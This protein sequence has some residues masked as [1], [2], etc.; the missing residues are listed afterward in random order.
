MAPQRDDALGS[1]VSQPAR[2]I[3]IEPD[4]F[5]FPADVACR[6]QTA[7]LALRTE[8]SAA[9]AFREPYIEVGHGPLVYRQYFER[10]VGGRRY[11]NLSPLFA[12]RRAAAPRVELRGGS[13]RWGREGALLLFDPP[14]AEG[15]TLVV[16]P[17]PDDAEIAAFGLYAGRRSWVVTVTAGEKGSPGGSAPRSPVATPRWRALLRV[18]DSI[19]VPQLGGV[20]QERCVNLVYPDGRL[21]DLND[22][23]PRPLAIACE[24]ELSRAM[25]RSWNRAPEFRDGEAGC[26][27]DGLVAELRTVLE[28]TRPGVVACPHPLLDGHPD[29]VFTTV[30]LEEA[31]RGMVAEKPLLLLYVV[32]ARAAPAFPFG[33][34]EGWVS[35]PPLGEDEAQADSIYS[36]PLPPDLQQTKYFAV[37]CKHDDRSYD[38][39]RPQTVAEVG[40]SIKRRL[41]ALL[42]GDGLHPTSFLRRAPRPNEI[43]WVVSATTLSQLVA[44][45]RARYPAAR[46]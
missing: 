28:K 10:G 33:P 6:G 43:F 9:G 20:A 31:M 24:G 11:L 2:P 35:L 14:P 40:R 21:S 42:G 44:R 22:G 32:H 27:W 37:E 19:A 41:G 8:S 45:A 34:R 18:W 46:G 5:A 36:H 16:A 12:E 13:M 17:H 29:H 30:A 26:T 38:S 25:L 15:E 23:N 39:G 3:A 7:F 4:G 1:R